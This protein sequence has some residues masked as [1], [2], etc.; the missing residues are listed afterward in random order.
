MV[1]YVS[2]VTIIQTQ[3]CLAHRKLVT[4]TQTQRMVIVFKNRNIFIVRFSYSFF[5][6]A[7]KTF[8]NCSCKFPPEAVQN[9][10]LRRTRQ[11]SKFDCKIWWSMNQVAVKITVE[12]KV[13]PGYCYRL[14]RFQIGVWKWGVSNLLCVADSL[15]Y[16]RLLKLIMSH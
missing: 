11:S 7:N 1:I 12:F 14:Q 5:L 10:L 8:V 4:N 6:L 2:L 15:A 13:T 16:E 3:P 9:V